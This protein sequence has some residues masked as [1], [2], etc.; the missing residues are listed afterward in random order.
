MRVAL[1]TGSVSRQGGGVFEAMV[2]LSGALRQQSGLDVHVLG[3]HDAGTDADAGAWGSV[4]V[5]AGQPH[6]PRGFGYSAAYSAG[7]RKLR[8]DIVHVHGL[9]MYASVAALW[10][11]AQTGTACVISPHGM[12]DRWALDNAAMK[13][14]IA[15]MLYQDRHFRRAACLHA[16]SASEC[17]SIRAFGLRNPVCVIPNGVASAAQP[18]APPAWRGALPAGAPVMLYL[19]RLHP[20]KGLPALLDAWAGCADGQHPWHLVIAGWDDGG[21]RATLEAQVETLRIAETVHFVGPQYGTDK[22]AS[23]ATASAFV[24]P[25]LSEGLPVAVLEA[26]SH[27]LPVLKTPHCNLPEGFEAGAAL[28]IETD[29][30]VIVR[31]LRR[32]LAMAPAEREA[33]GAAG[34]SLVARRYAWPALAKNMAAVYRWLLLR[35]TQPS[36]VT[37]PG[38]A[39]RPWDGGTALLRSAG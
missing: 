15:G 26:W 38:I 33:M 14:R 20:K 24:L 17:Q 10:W 16:V 19:G 21:H 36:C 28:R 22:D 1:L 18:T 29:A 32:L 5:T 13:K 31:Q 8:P 4:P 35:D 25:S 39:T 37:M 30:H 27:G 3:L 7:L 34:Q 2:G 6:G 12:L 11:A 23:F 9:W